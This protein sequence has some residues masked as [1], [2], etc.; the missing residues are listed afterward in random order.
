MKLWLFYKK[1]QVLGYIKFTI[2]SS[3]YSRSTN[4]MTIS[5]SND[6]TFST[7]T[8]VSTVDLFDAIAHGS[9]SNCKG[10]PGQKFDVGLSSPFRF[11]QLHLDSHFGSGA[12]LQHVNVKF[13]DPL[14]GKLAFGSSGIVLLV[15]HIILE[16]GSSHKTTEQRISH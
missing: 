15:M 1:N 7:W 14:C 11:V 5:V 4:Q 13:Q 6:V 3:M 9:N 8:Q 10:I 2:S 16:F 12:G